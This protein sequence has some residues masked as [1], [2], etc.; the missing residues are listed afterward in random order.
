[1]L[2]FKN[3]AA[4]HIDGNQWKLAVGSPN[5]ETGQVKLN[6]VGTYSNLETLK[7]DLSRFNV[8]DV[9]YSISSQYAASH[10]T[11]LI[12]PSNLQSQCEARHITTSEHLV[13]HCSFGNSS[14]L[15]AMAKTNLSDIAQFQPALKLTCNYSITHSNV[16]LAYSLLRNYSDKQRLCLGVL[17]FELNH[18]SF[19]VVQNGVVK[20]AL[21]KKIKADQ[22]L[23]IQLVEVLKTGGSF[24]EHP[25]KVDPKQPVYQA[26]Y[27]FL[28]GAG[29][30]TLDHLIA[31]KGSPFREKINV[32]EVDL[33]D[34]F[35]NQFISTENLDIAQQTELEYSSHRYSV[36]INAIAMQAEKLGIDLANSE[37]ELGKKLTINPTINIDEN[38]LD[39]VFAKAVGSAKTIAPAVAKQKYLVLVALLI[40]LGF[41]GYR[42]YDYNNQLINLETAYS[43][44]KAREGSLVGVKTDYELAQKRN[45][46]K[47]DRVNA[48]KNI[49]KTQMLVTNIFTDIQTLPYQSQFRDLVGI[50][51]L[52]INGSSVK[53]SGE[54]ID[55]IGAVAFVNKLQQN[56]NY[57]DVIPSYRSLDAVRCAYELNTRFIGNIPSTEMPL[58]KDTPLKKVSTNINQ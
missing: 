12:T 11:P 39:K 38:L 4:I 10:A 49:Q 55:K 36:P 44:E 51:S 14:I 53:V 57:E 7:T 43:K 58:P 45:K 13:D 40:C 16:V 24:C 47:N 33:L 5:L 42:Y 27:D 31:I 25:P 6:Y 9:T 23:T 30:C 3:L 15:A 20:T 41:N 29:E 46:L 17:Y 18:V 48:I 22:D 50:N 2:R 1:M 35:R 54:A 8:S 26:Y 52:T 19:L 21:W 32:R 56:P 34:S 28:F 37:N